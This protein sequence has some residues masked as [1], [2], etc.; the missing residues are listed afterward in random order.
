[1]SAMNDVGEDGNDR[2]EELSVSVE[3]N[4]NRLNWFRAQF[5]WNSLYVKNP[6]KIVIFIR[7]V[8]TAL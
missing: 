5:I 2:S 3:R 1:M 8:Q 6:K 4:M 7:F